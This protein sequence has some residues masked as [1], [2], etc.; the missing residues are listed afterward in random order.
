MEGWAVWLEVPPGGTAVPTS[1]PFP[2]PSH[3]PL[4]VGRVFL[5]SP[6][7]AQPQ[8]CIHGAQAC[9]HTHTQSPAAAASSSRTRR[10]VT[11]GAAVSHRALREYKLIKCFP[12]L[13]Q[14]PKSPSQA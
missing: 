7:P 12:A 3:R 5:A 8:V 2:R 10:V 11:P 14:G 9:T 6:S 1:F 13:L 4:F